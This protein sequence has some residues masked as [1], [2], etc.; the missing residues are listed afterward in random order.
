MKPRKRWVAAQG[1]VLLWLMLMVGGAQ[2]EAP[3]I[4]SL[5]P[6][7]T[8][9]ITVSVDMGQVWEA[10]AGAKATL[11]GQ[12]V[13]DLR[14]LIDEPTPLADEEAAIWGGSEQGYLTFSLDNAPSFRLYPN[15]IIEQTIQ[16]VRQL[17][18]IPQ[19]TVY[20][21]YCLTFPELVK[22]YLAPLDIDPEAPKAKPYRPGELEEIPIFLASDNSLKEAVFPHQEGLIQLGRAV[23]PAGGTQ[24][25]IVRYGEDGA[26]LWHKRYPDIPNPLRSQFLSLADGGFMV[27]LDGYET[28]QGPNKSTFNGRLIRFDGLGNILWQTTLEYGGSGQVRH[29]FQDN[30]G[31]I[32]TVGC[33]AIQS[34]RDDIVLMCYDLA[35]NRIAQTTFGGS[36]Y[37]M[38]DGAFYAPDMGL[39]VYGMTQSHDGD[40]TGRRNA[41][42]SATPFVA[43]FDEELN[44]K[45]HYVF[46]DKQDLFGCSVAVSREHIYVGGGLTKETG[47]VN[48]GAVYR[49]NAQ[50]EMTTFCIFD[51]PIDGLA[52]LPDQ[53]LLAVMGTA[54]HT[55]QII[56]KLDANLTLLTTIQDELTTHI[57][58]PPV[59]TG[60]GGFFTTSVLPVK[61]L[62]Q[63][64]F[65][66]KVRFDVVTVLSKYDEEG[67][68]LSRKVF[69]TSHLTEKVDEVL[70]LADGR[71]VVE[72]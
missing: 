67:N 22:Y 54:Q 45:W 71:V 6:N 63:P 33:C 64:P 3:V 25:Q 19:D 5:I 7:D 9:Q 12:Q 34:E 47:F 37:E 50:G 66:S 35:G 57:Q 56:L 51:Q 41:D 58:H 29:L 46:E 39:V 1:A 4:P 52:V 8:R 59:V 38:L 49:F 20:E 23:T 17:S 60:D 15:G 68:L 14:R 36:D 13:M 24:L 16:S 26:I 32:L 61:G 40:I 53:T 48:K 42:L 30:R 44:L 2:V 28:Y 62:P 11:T 55:S 65:M 10:S 18:R 31:Q 43:V 21:I 70:P 72:K 69:D 27:A